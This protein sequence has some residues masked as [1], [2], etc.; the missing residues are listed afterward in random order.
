MKRP[1]KHD[2]PAHE[3]AGLGSFATVVDPVDKVVFSQRVME[4]KP[5]CAIRVP[6]EVC[7]PLTGTVTAV[8]RVPEGTYI[9]RL[10]TSASLEA[11]V[12]A[13][14]AATLVAKLPLL[15]PGTRA[16]PP[17]KPVTRRDFVNKAKLSYR[18]AIFREA[19]AIDVDQLL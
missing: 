6:A 8:R 2:Q 12:S 5:P 17:P 7:L 18:D 14:K 10:G 11:L 15:R 1:P 13:K 9:R 4:R 19:A 16:G 3:R